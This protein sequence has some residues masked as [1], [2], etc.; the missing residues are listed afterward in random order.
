[1]ACFET[2]A[3]TAIM[4]ADGMLMMMMMD[5]TVCVATNGA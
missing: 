3:C 1:M 4:V 2:V 5:F